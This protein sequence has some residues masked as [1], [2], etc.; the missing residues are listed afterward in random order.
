[1]PGCCYREIHC[2]PI[3]VKYVIKYAIVY[4]AIFVLLGCGYYPE[5]TLYLSSTSLIPLPLKENPAVVSKER[6]DIAVKFDFYSG[7]ETKITVFLHNK[8]VIES[9]GVFQWTQELGTQPIDS[10]RYFYLTINANKTLMVQHVD[11]SVISVADESELPKRSSGPEKGGG[12]W[13]RRA[14]APK[15]LHLHHD[16]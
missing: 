9:V 10:K 15:S 14:I 4:L 12:H 2:K 16:L 7:G 13:G 11:S 5:S 6:R 8:A 3:G 1:M